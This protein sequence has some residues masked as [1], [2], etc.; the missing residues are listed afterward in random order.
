MAF[1]R[2][3]DLIRKKDVRPFVLTK[4]YKDSFICNEKR[5][6]EQHTVGLKRGEQLRI[7]HH[8]KPIFQSKLL[9][10]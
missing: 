8:R 4:A 7:T 3:L 10:E 1:F 2:N 9:V 6:L 5:T